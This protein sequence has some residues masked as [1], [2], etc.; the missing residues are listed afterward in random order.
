MKS[1]TII[2]G[3][4]LSFSLHCPAS[5][6]EIFTRTDN[7]FGVVPDGIT[8]VEVL[9][10]SEDLVRWDDLF[11]LGPDNNTHSINGIAA[12]HSFF[13]VRPFEVDPIPELR[14]H[15]ARYDPYLGSLIVSDELRYDFFGT[16]NEEGLP[17]AI[18]GMNIELG[19]SLFTWTEPPQPS[20]LLAPRPD[21]RPAPQQEDGQVESK[22]EGFV[23]ISLQGCM[24]LSSQPYL[25]YYYTDLATSIVH[26]KRVPLWHVRSEGD[27]E[28]Y[29]YCLETSNF[30]SELATD[31]LLYDAFE[32]AIQTFAP[33]PTE[34]LIPPLDNKLLERRT[35][36]PLVKK[37]N[38][39]ERRL[40]IGIALF[41]AYES[42][43]DNYQKNIF[44]EFREVEGFF[45]NLNIRAIIPTDDNNALYTTDWIRYDSYPQI[46]NSFEGELGPTLELTVPCETTLEYLPWESTATSTVRINLNGQLAARDEDVAGQLTEGQPESFLSVASA[47]WQNPTEFGTAF[48]STRIDLSDDK[49]TIIASNITNRSTSRVTASASASARVYF[50]IKES[51]MLTSGNRVNLKMKL[52]ELSGHGRLYAILG[53]NGRT[54]RSF[55]NNSSNEAIVELIVGRQYDIVF[56]AQGDYNNPANSKFEMKLLGTSLLSDE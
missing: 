15:H 7:L 47:S 31:E 9:Q 52:D 25:E 4:L 10:H 12:D 53:S 24:K 39:F 50:Q 41:R 36:T 37:M 17:A 42:V 3:A 14:Y 55:N 38:A 28:V 2:L 35:N 23:R 8:E 20:A 18:K 45:P 11:L 44:G 6:L 27:T 29:T 16:R 40:G 48:S 33:S 22:L 5:E 32:A 19:D 30:V 13:R 34:P 54:I 26:P 51:S 43:F 49:F 56:N 46:P 21:Q 1:L